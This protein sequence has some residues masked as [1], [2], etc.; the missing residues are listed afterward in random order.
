MRYP[1]PLRLNYMHRLR[2]CRKDGRE[3]Q[4]V[5]RLTGHILTLARFLLLFHL[6][7]CRCFDGFRVLQ[8]AQVF[9]FRFAFELHL[10]LLRF[11]VSGVQAFRRH[12]GKAD[13]IKIVPLSEV[14]TKDY[15][16]NIKKVSSEDP[17]SAHRVPPQ[18]IGKYSRFWR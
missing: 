17:M 11:R 2:L 16:F 9:L 7:L 3:L 8:R 5:A 10:L 18:M 13:G 4:H 6:A 15:F 14:A 1:V 12:A